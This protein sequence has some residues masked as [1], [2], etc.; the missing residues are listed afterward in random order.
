MEEKEKN[1]NEDLDDEDL[2]PTPPDGGWGWMVT[3]ASLVCNF[4]VD[5]IGYAFGVLLPIFAEHFEESKGKVSL[6]GSLLFGVYLCSGKYYCTCT[7]TLIKRKKNQIKKKTKM[8]YD[9][10]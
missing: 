4:I 1:Y 3:F 8:W 10:Q 5:G 7:K 6:V 2:I 9:S